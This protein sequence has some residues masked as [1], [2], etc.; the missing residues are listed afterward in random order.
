MN[1]CAGAKEEEKI[2]V[3]LS[4][5]KRRPICSFIQ[6]FPNNQPLI[7]YSTFPTV[8][9]ACSDLLFPRVLFRAVKPRLS[10]R[11]LPSIQQSRWD[12]ISR[13][14]PSTVNHW[15]ART[16]FHTVHPRL[17]LLLLALLV[18]MCEYCLKRCSLPFNTCS[19]QTPLHM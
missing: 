12:A 3:C 18:V 10:L 11:P 4:N 14:H 15:L 6:L 5:S 16:H 7:S 1:E 2:S 8:L 17:R 19:L 13:T 9:A